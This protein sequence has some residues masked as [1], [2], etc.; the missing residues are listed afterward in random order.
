MEFLPQTSKDF[1]SGLEKY[2]IFHF[3]GLRWLGFVAIKK[4]SS[5]CLVFHAACPSGRIFELSESLTLRSVMC[6]SPRFTP[7]LS[8]PVVN[9][10]LHSKAAIHGTMTRLRG[11]SLFWATAQL[12][13]MNFFTHMGITGLAAR[14]ELR[15]PN[16]HTGN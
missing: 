6:F 13:N 16:V 10:E 7:C 14:K 11:I 9:S 12:T 4:S 15:M 2:A 5:K 8:V 3:N 1:R